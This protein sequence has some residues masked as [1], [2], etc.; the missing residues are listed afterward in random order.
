MCKFRFELSSWDS[1]LSFFISLTMGTSSRSFPLC[2]QLITNLKHYIKYYIKMTFQNLKSW[3]NKKLKH[4]NLF[5][6]KEFKVKHESQRLQNVLLS[7]VNNKRDPVKCEFCDCSLSSKDWTGSDRYLKPIIG[8]SLQ[9]EHLASCRADSATESLSFLLKDLRL[10]HQ[11]L[12]LHLAALLFTIE[13]NGFDRTCQT[14]DQLKSQTFVFTVF[15]GS[16]SA[17]WFYK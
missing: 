10:S 3:Q 5:H 4:K 9:I 11:K 13:T 17:I 16:I 15:F 1:I 14:C 12:P 7:S 2:D 6:E 8:Y